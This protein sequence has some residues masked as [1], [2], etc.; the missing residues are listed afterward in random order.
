MK[1]PDFIKSNLLLKMTSLNAVVVSMRLLVSA[2][3]QRLLF[4]QVGA[5]GLYKI[6][7]LR[8]LTQLL[9]SVTSLGVFNGVVKY[10]AEYKDDKEKLKELFSS[11]FVFILIGSLVSGTFLFFFSDW[12]SFYLFNSTEYSYLVK[13]VAILTPSIAVQRVFNGVINGL[14]EYKKFAKIELI[15]Y[16]LAAGLLVLC[17]YTN[18]IDGA[19]MAI[20]LAPLIW[21]L[22]ILVIFFKLLKDTIQFSSLKLKAPLARNLLAFSLMSFVATVLLN[23]VHIDIRSMLAEQMTERD[24]GVWTN[25]TFISQNYMVFSSSLFTLYVLPKFSGIYTGSDFKKEVFNIY[26]TLLPIFGLGMLL[27]FFAKSIVVN[28]LYPGLDEM[29]PLF[30]WQLL[31]DFIRLASL[32]LAHQFLAKKMVRNF[33]FSEL[34]SLGLFYGFANYLVASYGVEGV[35][36]AHCIRYVIYFFVVSFLVWRYFRNKKTQNFDTGIANDIVSD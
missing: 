1:I 24:A 19:L 32:V 3:I 17:L 36:I 4:D 12:V 14:S 27:V 23:F 33:I 26:K 16:L 25:I 20:A 15:S 9:T 35:V 22:V 34:L 6:G 30:K 21:I 31:G 28:L 5:E 10:L 18:N 2:V 7:Q 13:F 8:S 11:T 29:L